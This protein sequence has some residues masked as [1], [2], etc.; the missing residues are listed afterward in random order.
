MKKLQITFA[1]TLL[2]VASLTGQAGSDRPVHEIHS[3]M[4]YNFIKYIQWPGYDSSQDFVIGVIG[5]D[6]VYSTLTTWYDG[7]VRG[8]KKY[9]VKKFS[10]VN[11]ITGCHIIYVGKNEGKSF[12]SIQRKLAGYPTLTITDAPGLGQKGSAINFRT[13]NNKLVFELNQKT[14]DKANLKVSGQLAAM[15]ILI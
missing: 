14:V 2:L 9:A 6:N 4:I 3:M 5:D 7:K 12:E 1:L 8:D 13:V 11:D 15:A 10:S